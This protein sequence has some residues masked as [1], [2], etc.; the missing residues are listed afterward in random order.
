M[1]AR[2]RLGCLVSLVVLGVAPP[3]LA[4][5]ADA[6]PVDLAARPAQ[7]AAPNQTG[8]R[9]ALLER[10]SRLNQ[11]DQFMF[12]QE[13]ATLWGMS[14]DDRVV[15]TKEWYEGTAAAGK[16]T[17][18]SAQLVG[19]DP[20]VLGVSLGMLAFEPVAWH[21]RPV[22]A[23]AIRRQVAQG[24]VVTM[25]WHAPSCDSGGHATAALGTVQVG[26][27][28]V[29]IQ[30]LAGGTSFYAEDEYTRPI[31]GLGDVP[32][33]LKC[34]CQIANDRPLTAGVYQGLGGRSW[35]IAQ[36][37][38]AAQVMREQ[39]LDGLPI[40]VRPFHEHTGPWFW[41][42]Q[43]YW[44]CAALLGDPG[45][46][47]GAEAFKQMNRIFIEALRAEPGM[48]ELLFAY[49]P[50]RLS[51]LAE[52]EAPL[53]EGGGDGLARA[54][55][56]LEDP[57]GFARDRLRAR[58]VR[59]LHAA[60]LSF[61]SPAQ[62]AVKL[63]AARAAGRG[64][65]VYVN[66][67]RPF[68]AEG[69]AGDEL[70]DVL[71]IDLYHPLGRPA[72]ASDL[73][74]FGLLLRVVAEEAHARGKPFAW[75][76]AGTYRLPLVQLQAAVPR[77]QPIVVNTQKDVEDALA[78]LFDP[79]DRAALLRHFGL[80]APGPIVVRPSERAAVMP[81]P[82]EDW[83]N[84]QLLPLAKQAHVAYALTWQTYYDPSRAE[85]YYYSYLPYP[86]H[87]AAAAFRRFHDDSAT[88]FLSD[89]C[90]LR[91]HPVGQPGAQPGLLEGRSPAR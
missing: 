36:A 78:H 64:A 40:I 53:R 58:I 52:L 60:G 2:P 38:Y 32:E 44:N 24:G 56:K 25:D 61:D 63:S 7:S 35:L 82:P 70:F 20:A 30:A 90:G 77:A 37:K 59:E 18:D 27:Q 45:A 81:T 91:E 6:A 74:E 3:R 55:H 33:P 28:Q 85:H 48:G 46:V 29:A 8:A 1:R 34:V 50:D 71:G 16:F 83:Y 49:S 62:A 51:S 4:R 22:I 17:S 10:L 88:C 67:R 26:G 80:R 5:A 69:F 19:D 43:P 47:T 57:N 11:S 66:Q 21:R 75:T 31:T 68:Y 84:Q 12:G 89:R 87:V 9:A 54:R 13:N 73:R 23:Q 65:T 86:G 39:K 79:V 72:G 41:W 76:E 14:L 15:S 42:G